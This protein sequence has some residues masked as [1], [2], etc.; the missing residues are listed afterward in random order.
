MTD[1]PALEP[2][3]YQPNLK[4]FEMAAMSQAASF[5]RIADALETMASKGQ[6]PL[7][8]SGMI[9]RRNDAPAAFQPVTDAQGFKAWPGRVKPPCDPADEVIVRRRDG[10]TQQAHA[11]T[12]YWMHGSQVQDTGPNGE[13]IPR[14]DQPGDIVAWK[15]A[16]ADPAMNEGR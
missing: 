12:L 6:S 14:P 8:L 11:G 10:N 7:A 13:L 5:K 9:T 2:L 16:P 1:E 3:N 15:L 4:P